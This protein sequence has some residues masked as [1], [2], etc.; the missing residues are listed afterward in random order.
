[1]TLYHCLPPFW[2]IQIHF[3]TNNKSPVSTKTLIRIYLTIKTTSIINFHN[4]KT[5]SLFMNS[6]AF[7]G[8]S[9]NMKTSASFFAYLYAGF[10]SGQSF[11][12]VFL[13]IY[14]QHHKHDL[15]CL[16]F[17][18]DCL[19]HRRYGIRNKHLHPSKLI[20]YEEVERN[21]PFRP[22]L[23]MYKMFHR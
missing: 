9:P 20:L 21:T 19:H 2:N 14:H 5:L 3:S 4:L 17:H 6:I 10:S 23:L 13:V 8:I 1:M 16:L 7:L 12:R 11:V 15:F 18:I 22:N